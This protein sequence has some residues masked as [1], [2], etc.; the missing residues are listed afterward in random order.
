[1]SQSLLKVSLE[2]SKGRSVT[3]GPECV[4]LAP[5]AGVA[6]E[7]KVLLVR[8]QNLT[9]TQGQITKFKTDCGFC[10]SQWRTRRGSCQRVFYRPQSEERARYFPET[11]L[12]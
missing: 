3:G 11:Q 7:H 9:N 8:R 12:L 5:P 1:M 2:L 4:L 10:R 6:G